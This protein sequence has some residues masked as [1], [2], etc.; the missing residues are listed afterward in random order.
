MI[1]IRYI[2]DERDFSFP[3]DSVLSIDEFNTMTIDIVLNT[4]RQERFMIGADNFYA[5]VF[6]DENMVD[7]YRLVE[8]DCSTSDDLDDLSDVIVVA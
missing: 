7:E 4:G 1:F 5:K 3:L 8:I 2:D 6:S